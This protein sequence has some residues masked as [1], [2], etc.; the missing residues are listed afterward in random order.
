MFSVWDHTTMH[1][2]EFCELWRACFSGVRFLPIRLF[3]LFIYCLQVLLIILVCCFFDF[4]PQLIALLFVS[5]FVLFSSLLCLSRDPWLY[6][7]IYIYIIIL[8]IYYIIHIYAYM[9]FLICLDFHEVG[10]CNCAS[11]FNKLGR[12]FCQSVSLF[13]SS[14]LFVW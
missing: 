10:S 3:A 8:Y 9:T 4:F 5:F 1:V 14:S 7:Y 6:I 13:V 12:S 11:G 2:F